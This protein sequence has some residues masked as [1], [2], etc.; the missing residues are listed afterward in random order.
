MRSMSCR[1]D[2][3]LSLSLVHGFSSAP[4]TS[5]DFPTS[6][7]PVN[8]DLVYTFHTWKSIQRF[9]QKSND[10]ILSLNNGPIT[11]SCLQG[12]LQSRAVLLTGRCVGEQ[13]AN[14]P[15]EEVGVDTEQLG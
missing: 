15:S 10:L 14:L 12:K 11:A 7:Y 13:Q 4:P 3:F 5:T 9:Q 8:N 2:L 1:S 6:F